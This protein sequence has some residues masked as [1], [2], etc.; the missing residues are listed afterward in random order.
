MQSH[1]P[2][3]LYSY[4]IATIQIIQRYQNTI[5]QNNN[6]NNREGNSMMI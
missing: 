3:D 1:E 4:S 2:D 5:K 6:N